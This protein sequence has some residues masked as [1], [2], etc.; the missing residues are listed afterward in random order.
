MEPNSTMPEAP[1]EK[2]NGALIGTIIIILILV[3]G[4][5]YLFSK[6]QE[7]TSVIEE[8]MIEETADL[9][10]EEAN[11]SESDDLESIEADLNNEMEIEVSDEELEK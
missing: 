10:E 7:D 5:I 9:P 1:K 6:N 11:L 4:G 8:P 3:I 2:S